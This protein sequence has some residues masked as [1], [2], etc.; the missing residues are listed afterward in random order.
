MAQVRSRG[1]GTASGGIDSGIDDS[2]PSGSGKGAEGEKK[3]DDGSDGDWM[4][5]SY[6]GSMTCWVQLIMKTALAVLGWH[7][8]VTGQEVYVYTEAVFGLFVAVNTVDMVWHG[9][10]GTAS[11]WFHHSITYLGLYLA[12]TSSDVSRRYVCW[13]AVAETVAPFYQL[14]KLNQFPMVFRYLAIC[15]N[16]LVRLP[17]FIFLFYRTTSD[18]HA[19]FTQPVAPQGVVPAVWILWAISCFGYLGLD[20]I[21]TKSMIKSVEKMRSKSKRG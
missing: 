10:D 1:S 21:W 17:Y 20:Y 13:N 2:M 7:C 15:T 16:F 19:Y 8:A 5:K 3:G 6:F 18:L 14:I 4:V 12:W 11:E 9:K